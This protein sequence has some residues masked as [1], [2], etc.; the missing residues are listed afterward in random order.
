MLASVAPT[1][2]TIDNARFVERFGWSAQAA[3]RTQQLDAPFHKH[4][5]QIVLGARVGFGELILAALAGGAEGRV[6]H[7]H[8]EGLADQVEQADAVHGVLGHEAALK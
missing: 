1:Q 4:G 8:I 7:H 5:Q 2:P 6:H 3:A